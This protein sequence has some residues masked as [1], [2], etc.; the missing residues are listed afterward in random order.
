MGATSDDPEPE[1]DT[2]VETAKLWTL[3][4]VYDEVDSAPSGPSGAI[5]KGDREALQTMARVETELISQG[6]WAA[7]PATL[8]AALGLQ[9]QEIANC[10]VLAWLLDPLAPHGLGATTLRSLLQHLNSVSQEP[11]FPSFGGLERTTVVLEEARGR[12][13][14]DVILYGPSW[15]IVIE[16][17]MGA[18][19]QPEQGQRL[20]ANWPDAIYVFLTKR[21]RAMSTAGASVWLPLTWTTVLNFV[22]D[23]LR[24]AEKPPT[25]AARTARAAVRDYLITTRHMEHADQ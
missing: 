24:S 16:A 20:A 6:R 4:R 11:L 15:A 25:P 10:R 18:A 17:K 5:L 13:R 19:E 2:S 23:A 9:H 22:R 7:G 1:F 3:R 8:F 21:G 14:A 12:T